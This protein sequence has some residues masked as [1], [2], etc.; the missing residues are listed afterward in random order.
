MT[1]QRRR[2]WVVAGVCVLLVAAGTV[3]WSRDRD[4]CGDSVHSVSAARS[5]SP[6]LDAGGQAQEP[7]QH[8]D[9][10]VRTLAADPAPVGPV[11]G[12]VGYDYQQWAQV[13]SYAQGIG[14]RTRDNPDFTML[15]DRTLHPRWS[16]QVDTRHSTYDASDRRYLVA[17]MPSK[18]APDLVALDADTG[19]RLWCAH[20]DGPRVHGSDP[21]ATQFLSDQDVVVLGPGGHGRERV[22]RL[23]AKDGAV[24]WKRDVDAD[25]GDFLGDLGDGMLVAGGR[26]QYRLVDAG[27]TGKRRAGTALVGLSAKDGLTEWTR[28]EPAGSDLHVVGADPASGSAVVQQ[29]SNSSGVTRLEAIDREGHETWSVVPAAGRYFDAAL[30]SGRVLVR[31]GDRWS[32]YELSDGHRLWTTTVPAKPQFL[33]Y[34]FQLDDVP[35]LDPDHVLMGGTTGLHTLDLGTGRMTDARLP[36]DGIN[37][38]Y[39]PYQLAVS[40]RLIAVATNTAAV[41]VRRDP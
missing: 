26:P 11:V 21:F 23:A 4:T 12:A 17:T 22:V 37:T 14:V 25:A 10:L 6:F 20:L 2:A 39:W 29:W 1:K 33:P 16:V 9:T 19:H 40:D 5:R 28:P 15:D 35:L 13:S 24:R 31:V 18:A 41:V 3:A 27:D 32:A 34:G 38:T 8:R 30:R 36:T 7:D